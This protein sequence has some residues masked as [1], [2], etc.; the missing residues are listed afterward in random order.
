M[1]LLGDC[2]DLVQATLRIDT[3]PIASPAALRPVRVSSSR[4]EYPTVC[5]ILRTFPLDKIRNV[6]YFS[7]AFNYCQL[8]GGSR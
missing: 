3:A 8:A 7:T 4:A 5:G 2:K 1:S 6:W